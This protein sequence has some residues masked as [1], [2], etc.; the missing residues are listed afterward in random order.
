MAEAF[1]VIGLVSAVTTLTEQGGKIIRRLKDAKTSTGAFDDIATQLPLILESIEELKS[2]PVANTSDESLGLSLLRVVDGCRRQ[3]QQ[4][5]DLLESCLILPGDGRLRKVFKAGKAVKS[6]KRIRSILNTLETYKTTLIL[7]LGKPTDPKTTSGSVVR[8]LVKLPALRVSSFVGRDELM[9][10]LIKA[11]VP[12]EPPKVICLHAMGGQGKT[13][14]ALECCRRLQV[15]Q[16]FQTIIWIDATSQET[17]AAEYRL[18][19][20]KLSGN[21]PPSPDLAEAR[22]FQQRLEDWPEPFL[23]VFDNC[24]QPAA[25]QVVKEYLPR[26]P[27]GVTLCTS[28]HLDCDRLGQ[29][30]DVPPMSDSDASELLLS[31]CKAAKV[32]GNVAK[33]SQITKVLGHL[34]LAVDQAA[35]YIKGRRIPLENF[36]EH[37]MSRKSVILKHIPDV[38]EYRKYQVD[39]EKA[40]SLSVFAT[41]DLAFEDFDREDDDYHHVRE[42]LGFL[43]A[44]HHQRIPEMLCRSSAQNCPAPWATYFIIDGQWDSGKYQDL[45]AKLLAKSLIIDMSFEG[46]QTLV[47]LHPLVQE[48]ALLRLS[49]SEQAESTRTAAIAWG[50]WITH[51]NSQ[52]KG[53]SDHHQ[54]SLLQC[55]KF[56]ANAVMALLPDPCKDVISDIY[57]SIQNFDN[58]HG[59]ADT[60]EEDIEE[61]RSQL[62]LKF[63]RLL[64]VL[65]TCIDPVHSD[66]DPRY[67]RLKQ[68]NQVLRD[69]LVQMRGF[70]EETLPTDIHRDFY[71]PIASIILTAQRD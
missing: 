27:N 65:E 70:S 17:I 22:G 66:G 59:D 48:W 28:R 64:G 35:S 19:L 47:S 21:A 20:S 37:Y 29:V 68:D 26:N 50:H 18:L 56:S 33:A 45:V 15:L 46:E 61:E 38:W 7:Y 53:P 62:I 12:T 3:V 24:D 52:Q 34:P 60:K 51:H 32:N 1:A 31:R 4:L 49:D 67:Q 44:F 30:I 16:A 69:L 54:S 23:L 8:I 14:I 43:A 36:L 6:E 71:G 41:C 57:Q 42:L 2:T 11:L 5:E 39:D 40:T 25:L 9:Q 13:Q 55:S 10:D 63:D 58:F